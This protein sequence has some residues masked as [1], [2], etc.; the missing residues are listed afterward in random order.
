MWTV[1]ISVWEGLA[2]HVDRCLQI[3]DTQCITF[4]TLKLNEHMYLLLE[5]LNILTWLNIFAYKTALYD[6]SS[7]VVN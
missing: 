4:I 3:S 2:S 5:I 6:S 7:R 1:L